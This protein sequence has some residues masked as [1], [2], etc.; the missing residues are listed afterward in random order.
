MLADRFAALLFYVA[1][2]AGVVTFLAWTVAGDVD[3]AV[4]IDANHLA[5]TNDGTLPAGTRILART[6]PYDH[7]NMTTTTAGPSTT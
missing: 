5:F 1:V 6:G 2:G 4:M 7:C 3:A